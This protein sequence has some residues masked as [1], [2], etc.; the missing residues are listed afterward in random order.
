MST[1]NFNWSMKFE[2]RNDI[3]N[4]GI[5]RRRNLR[6]NTIAIIPVSAL[7]K[8]PKRYIA[9]IISPQ[10]PLMS[11][12]VHNAWATM[13]DFMRPQRLLTISLPNKRPVSVRNVTPPTLRRHGCRTG[14]TTLRRF[15]TFCNLSRRFV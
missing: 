13:C 11:K 8:A 9:M 7:H 1:S 10:V 2:L 5:G 4:R 3:L 6:Q 15:A 12:R 14:G